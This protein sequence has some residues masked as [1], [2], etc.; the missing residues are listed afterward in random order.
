[1]GCFVVSLS[2]QLVV[3]GTLQGHGE[4]KWSFVIVENQGQ[5][6]EDNRVR[7]NGHAWQVMSMGTAIH[8]TGMCKRTRQYQ[9]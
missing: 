5:L 3:S 9:H 2:D 8:G 1:M 6:S 4:A 7:V